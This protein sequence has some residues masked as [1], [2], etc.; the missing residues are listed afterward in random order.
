[1]NTSLFQLQFNKLSSKYN[2]ILSKKSVSLFTGNRSLYS[3]P[4]QI[5]CLEFILDYWSSTN[6][7]AIQYLGIYSH[8]SNREWHGAATGEIQ[9]SN[10][11]KILHQEGAQKLF[12][13]E[14]VMALSFPEFK[15][16]LDNAFTYLFLWSCVEPGAG[17]DNSYGF[18]PAQYILWFLE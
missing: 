13:R 6:I 10:Q 11:Y 18:L 2:Q 3:W 15:K 16:H 5:L 12:L 14:V 4:A 1:M 17:L 8:Y 7:K 9:A